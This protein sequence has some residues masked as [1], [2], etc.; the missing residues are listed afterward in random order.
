[1]ADNRPMFGLSINRDQK[2]EE[3]AAAY[4]FA[5]PLVDDGAIQIDTQ[6]GKSGLT[7]AYVLSMDAGVSSDA[8][9]IERYRTLALYAKIDFAV[10]EITNEAI[11]VDDEQPV[12]S[13]DLTELEKEIPENVREAIEQEFQN[14]LN[15]LKFRFKGYELFRRWYVDSRLVFH[16]IVDPNEP[17]RGIIELRPLDPRKVKRVKE[18]TT[19]PDPF[20]GAEVKRVVDDYFIYVEA[21]VTYNRQ[22]SGQLF[23][24]ASYMQGQAPKGSG[25][26]K[27]SPDAIAFVHSGLVDPTSGIIYGYL[28]KALKVTNQLRI[29][30]DSLVVYRLSRAP[31]RRIFYIDTGNLPPAKAMQLV[32]QTQNMYRS[33]VVYDAK[34]GEIADQ[35]RTMAM[36]E[37]FFVPRTNGNKGTE[38]DTLAGAENLGVIDDIEYFNQELWHSLNVP[39]SRFKTDV[40]AI[41]GSGAEITREE[42]K[43]SKFIARLRTQ[44]SILFSDLLKTQ[45]I[46]KGILTEGEWEYICDRVQYKFA[47]NTHFAEA[48]EAEVRLRRF[49]QLAEVDPFVGKYFSKRWVQ[50]NILRMS[51]EDIEAEEAQMLAEL[52][53]QMQA[54]QGV[55]PGAQSA[56]EMRDLPEEEE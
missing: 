33:K 13:L 11:V 10:D 6:G 4:S 8:E 41:F 24:D 7:H 12:V 17:E 54:A 26:V 30:E 48:K 14:I 5:P 21:I 56:H 16:K 40:S 43:F 39:S 42:I 37:D 22:F 34:T 15:L 36:Q 25:I 1:M 46:L 35:R 38:I 45:L 44:F 19:E 31:E 47:T 49:E 50:M 27:I 55:A 52:E 18:I 2:R 28:Q 23:G 32:K 3:Q 51:E 53:M 29:L 9:L 20:T